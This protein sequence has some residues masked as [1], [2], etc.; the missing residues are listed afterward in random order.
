MRLYWFCKR[1]KYGIDVP[2]NLLKKD[3]QDVVANPVQKI[4]AVFSKMYMDEKYSVAEKMD[5]SF[6]GTKIL[7][8]EEI[9][10]LLERE[11][12]NMESD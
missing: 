3:I 7:F 12:Q 5:K 9:E 4:Y 11:N 1:P 8:S 10:K 6:R 2:N